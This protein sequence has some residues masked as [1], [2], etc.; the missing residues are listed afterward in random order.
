MKPSYSPIVTP[1]GEEDT[2]E[3]WS[4]DKFHPARGRGRKNR[5]IGIVIFYVCRFFDFTNNDSV[6]LQNIFYH[7]ELFMFFIIYHLERLM[8]LR[9]KYGLFL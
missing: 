9:L 5:R 7:P 2:I 6:W 1:L 4:A 8:D 3:R